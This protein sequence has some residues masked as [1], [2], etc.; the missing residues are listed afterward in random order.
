MGLIL[1]QQLA[2]FIPIHS[3]SFIQ[4][5]VCICGTLLETV[6]FVKVGDE[7]VAEATAAEREWLMPWLN[8]WLVRVFRRLD[9][10][11]FFGSQQKHVVGFKGLRRT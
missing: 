10:G 8:E 6:C 9:H 3:I 11:H 7:Q 5:V 1:R 4:V 2:P